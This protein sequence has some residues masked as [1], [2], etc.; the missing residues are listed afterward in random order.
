MRALA[1]L[2]TLAIAAAAAQVARADGD[3]ASDYLLGEKVFL[4][5]DAKF[6]PKQA[7]EL[8]GLVTAANRAGF[9][10]RVAVIFSDYDMG[11]V[12]TL[13]RKPH[14]YAKFLGLELGFVYKQRLLVVMPNGLGFNWPKHPT[15]AEYALLGK[16]PTGRSPAQLL[17]AATTAVTRLAAADGVQVAAPAH[18]TTPAQRNAH[19][20]EIILAVVLGV[21]AL[22]AGARYLIRRARRV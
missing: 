13:W 21:L 12:T 20:R 2:A 5:Y 14:T 16:I 11:S 22:A 18:V 6:P 17:T 9:K 3:P 8:S 15:Q 4:P 19:D 10:I 1:L 7:A